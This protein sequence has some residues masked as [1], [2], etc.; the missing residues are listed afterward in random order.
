MEH[1]VACAIECRNC[2]KECRKIATIF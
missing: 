1:C 2:A